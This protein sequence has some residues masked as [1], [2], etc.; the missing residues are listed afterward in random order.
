MLVRAQEKEAKRLPIALAIVLLLLSSL[1]LT[2][3]ISAAATAH[4][5]ILIN[6]N[7]GF[8][9]ANGVTGG[10][11]IATDPYTIGPL[12]INASSA[13]GI[14]IL[15][16]SAYFQLLGV[17]VHSGGTNY[18]GLLLL[19]VTNA[20]VANSTFDGNERGIDITNSN[21]VTVTNSNVSHSAREG[22]LASA[23]SHV[24][25]R[26][27]NVTNNSGGGVEFSQSADSTTSGNAIGWNMGPGILFDNSVD[28][29]ARRNVFTMNGLVIN[30]SALIHYASHSITSDNR[31]NGK[32]LYYFRNCV[33]VTLNKVPVGQLIAANCGGVRAI[34]VNI[35]NTDAGVQ[36][37]Y[38]AG[39]E[40]SNTA[41]SSIRGYGVQVGYS[42]NITVV[43]SNVSTSSAGGITGQTSTDVTIA[44]TNITRDGPFG[45]RLDTSTNVTIK[46]SRISLSGEGLRL[47]YCTGVVLLGNN[48]SNDTT[49]ANLSSPSALTA[50]GNSFTN[51]GVGLALRAMWPSNDV[52]I[53]HNNFVDNMKQAFVQM[54]TP[55]KWDDGYPGGGNYWSDYGGVDQCSGVNQTICPDPDGIGDTPYIIDPSNRDR[56]PLM[57]PYRPARMPP[58]AFFQVFSSPVD[59]SQNITVDASMSA[60]L[61]EPPVVLQVRWDW[62]NDGSWDTSWNT[63]KTAQHRYGLVG[64]YTVRLEVMDKGGLIANATMQVI[65]GD[66]IPPTINVALVSDVSVGQLVTIAANV[67]DAGG[68]R[69]VLLFYIV[70]GQPNFQIV[71]MTYVGGSTYQGVIPA[72]AS[73]GVV[74]FYIVA[75]DSFGNEMRA[76]QNWEYYRVNVTASA[77]LPRYALLAAIALLS[78][79]IAV[80]AAMVL[81]RRR[82][83]GRAKRSG[84][85]QPPKE[86]AELIAE[87]AD[88]QR[89]VRS[90]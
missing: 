52:L 90:R 10:S 51:N 71:P 43:G 47:S 53:H 82:R 25:I 77:A 41:I 62:E 50:V 81:T 30:G 86:G 42:F 22:I 84:G 31:V 34:S 56:Y 15:N 75:T 89:N 64:N 54:Q 23:S 28:M 63:T 48:F 72:Q 57:T 61:V 35:S 73:A 13:I 36:L 14:A 4:S 79:G 29:I 49:G 6:G 66:F 9:P 87:D 26:Y 58:L 39:A 33:S 8:T 44:Q 78:L 65:V 80:I 1:F 5:P 60:D 67:T 85:P 32:P 40:V 16:T 18:Q 68:I 19:N 76:P 17:Y 21:H 11:G 45:V 38:V 2:P 12:D 7:G 70:V 88:S 24:S 59:M 74:A 69:Q 55:P 20:E 83:H 46:G 3:R 37:Y 27:N